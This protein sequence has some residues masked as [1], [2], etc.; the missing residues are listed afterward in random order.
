MVID[1]GRVLSPG[2]RLEGGGW[3]GG[4]LGVGFG[5]GGSCMEFVHSVSQVLYHVN[6]GVYY[7]QPCKCK[8]EGTFQIHFQIARSPSPQ[9]VGMNGI[10][11]L[12]LNL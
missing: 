5:G 12:A 2:C 6:S 4:F 9:I 1:G 3:G 10:L 7:M 8:T 11:P